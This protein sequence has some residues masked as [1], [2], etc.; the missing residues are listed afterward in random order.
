M[1]SRHFPVIYWAPLASVWLA[2][3]VLAIISGT[4]Y[5]AAAALACLGLLVLSVRLDVVQRR[6]WA[7]LAATVADME[8]RHRKRLHDR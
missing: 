3:S 6:R 5:L 4:A 7:A 8:A 2:L 1:N